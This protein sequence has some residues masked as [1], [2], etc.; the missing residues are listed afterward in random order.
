MIGTRILLVVGLVG[1]A[2]SMPAGPGKL[3]FHNQEPITL[4]NDRVPLAKAPPSF[5]QGLVE[6]YLTGDLVEP[7]RRV[8][9][10]GDERPA[11]NVNSIGG[12][13]DSAWFTN[14][15]VTPEQVR[16]GPGRGGPDRSKPWRVVGVKIGGMSLGITFVDALDDRYVLKFDEREFPE[17]ET[18]ADVI[19]QR[20]TWA[21][22]Y[23][24]PDNEVVTFRRDQLVLDPKAEIKNR[25]GSK[26]AMTQADFDKYIDSVDHVNGSY[27][28]LASRHIDGKVVGGVEPQ[29]VRKDDPNDRVPHE[30]RRDL[31]G[32]R[33]LWAWVNHPDLKSQNALASVVE[34]NYVK[35][36]MLDFGDSLG[37]INKVTAVPR[38]GYRTTY[39]PRS[40]L[41]SLVS[42]GIH[43]HPWERTA[44][45]P[46]L[47]GL[48]HFESEHFE[49]ATWTP[50][51]K[52]RP[53]DLADRFDQLWA[54]EIM[55]RF[56]PAHIR[57]AVEAGQY[58]DRRTTEYVIKTLLERQRKIGRWALGRV[59]PI[60]RLEVRE[61]AGAISVCFDDLWLRHGYGVDAATRYV[62]AT[63][64][65]DGR[66]LARGPRVNA[67]SGGR[68][69]LPPIRPGTARDGYTIVRIDIRRGDDRVPPAFVHIA[70]GAGG[71]RVIGIDRR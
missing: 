3:R 11:Q 66:A 30:L 28:A 46:E 54:T 16:R 61:R 12:V 43:V 38:L 40:W 60:S 19:V 53:T 71:F 17:T 51:H 63:Y 62:T 39:A 29:G 34:G 1:C 10:V 41:V 18:A 70:R 5:D 2:G 35:W 37:V 21:F 8:L 32:Q 50:N 26:R 23:N 65:Y 20:L 69:C 22:G 64:D 24:V 44:R 31:R 68:T 58:T 27:R 67:L 57:A 45:Y 49:P 48:G 47:R 9:T 56:T 15:T 4:V 13:P 36:F 25:D 55:L 42:F 6:Y 52:W 33:V 59:A 7:T 14:R